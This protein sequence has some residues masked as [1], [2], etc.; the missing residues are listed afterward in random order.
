MRSRIPLFAFLTDTTDKKSL[1][2]SR[3]DIASIV[4]WSLLDTEYKYRRI[5]LHFNSKWKSYSY[6]ISSYSTVTD[7]SRYLTLKNRITW[8]TRKYS[9][10]M[11]YSYKAGV[12]KGTYPRTLEFQGGYT[13]PK[14]FRIKLKGLS[15]DIKEPE[16][17]IDIL[18]LQKWW[19]SK[20]LILDWSIKLPFKDVDLTDDMYYQ[21]RLHTKF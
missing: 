10:G 11:G 14:L 19:I 12:Y 20:Q 5:T 17:Y 4:H 18:I 16:K 13:I 1:L 8:T 6:R 21:A 7:S 3:L 15:R 9:L 2:R